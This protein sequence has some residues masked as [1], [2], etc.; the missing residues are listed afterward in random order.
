MKIRVDLR[1]ND[2]H[3]N[4]QWTR[5]RGTAWLWGLVLAWLNEGLARWSEK[6]I[7]GGNPPCEGFA[8]Y[9]PISFNL[10]ERDYCDSARFFNYLGNKY[11]TVIEGSYGSDVV[12]AILEELANVHTSRGAMLAIERALDRFCPRSSGYGK[13]Y[14]EW[15]KGNY[16]DDTGN[17]PSMRAGAPL[18]PWW[19]EAGEIGWGGD[20]YAWHEF[21]LPFRFLA[22]GLLNKGQR[23]CYTADSREEMM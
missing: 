9:K 20:K 12:R 21:S 1:T 10:L 13:A 17:S 4:H 22:W 15:A 11:G 7:A 18:R 6:L 14:E 23:W 2:K 16:V 19:K 5:V 8:S 3:L